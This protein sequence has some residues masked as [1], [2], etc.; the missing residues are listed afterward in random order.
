VEIPI[1]VQYGN[2]ET[3]LLDASAGWA[4]HKILVPIGTKWCKE[5]VDIATTYKDFLNYV[6]YSEECWN[7]NIELANIYSHPKDNY[8]PRSTMPEKILISTASKTTYRS[9]G[10]NTTGGYQGE[11][12]LS[13]KA[14]LFNK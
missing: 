1:Y 12:V 3:L 5:R 13:R 9:N 11:E 4:P 2:G 6:N 14:N 10:S 7:K 8:Q